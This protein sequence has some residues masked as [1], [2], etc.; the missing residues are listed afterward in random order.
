[1]FDGFSGWTVLNIPDLKYG[2]VAL[3][4]ETFHPSNSNIPTTGW[5]SEND[6]TSLRARFLKGSPS[7]E[8]CDEFKFEFAIDGT[9]TSWSKDEFLERLH[10]VQRVVETVTILKDPNYTGGEEKEVE[11]AFR[12]TG[13]GRIKTFLFSHI[14]W[15]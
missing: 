5:K 12:I 6:Q 10:Q 8:Y 3:K 9:V 15:A 7:P 1:M 4:F 14:Y 2:Y 11:V 13:C